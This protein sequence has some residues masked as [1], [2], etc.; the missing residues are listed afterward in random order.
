MWLSWL[1]T[2]YS[3]A[4]Y[5]PPRARSTPPPTLAPPARAPPTRRWAAGGRSGRRRASPATHCLLRQWW[6]RGGARA[7]L[8]THQPSSCWFLATLLHPIFIFHP[9]TTSHQ[10]AAHP[11]GHMH[12]AA[13]YSHQTKTAPHCLLRT[14]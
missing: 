11:G 6:L 13:Q 14:S 8:T 3:T 10:P 7:G 12:A 4:C 5:F 1:P 2:A 9:T